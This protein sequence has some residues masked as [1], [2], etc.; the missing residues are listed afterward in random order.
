MKLTAEQIFDLFVHRK[1]CYSLQQPTGAYYIQKE[2][3]TIDLIKQHLKG[4]KTIGIYVLDTDNTVK[5]ACVDIDGDE[6]E[7]WKLYPEAI[8]VY[9]C[10]N[11]FPRILEFSGR[12]G[13]HIWIFF[14]KKVPAQFAQ[15]LV[16]ARLNR[17]D[18]NKYEVFPKQTS[19]SE[20]RKY[21]NLVKLPFAKH[22]VSGKYSRILKAEGI[23]ND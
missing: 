11:D 2:P 7:V 13:F 5:W 1:D 6:H 20:S 16:K 10:F 19:L 22:K 3:I 21:G 18:L 8:I 9:N 15:L 4:D 12:K 17:P 14:N 23:L